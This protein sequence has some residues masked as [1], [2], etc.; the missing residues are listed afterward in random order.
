MLESPAHGNL[1][2]IIKELQQERDR[3]DAAIE[4]LTSLGET[5]PKTHGAPRSHECVLCYIGR[6]R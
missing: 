4:A 5:S 1:D 3:I 2:T 6:S